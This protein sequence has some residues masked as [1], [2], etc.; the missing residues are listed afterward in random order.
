[1][2]VHLVLKNNLASLRGKHLTF[3]GSAHRHLIRSFSSHHRQ[4]KVSRNSPDNAKSLKEFYLLEHPETF[5]SVDPKISNL[6]FKSAHRFTLFSRGALCA[7]SYLE[8]QPL[9]G[10]TSRHHTLKHPHF[11]GIFIHFLLNMLV[12]KARITQQ[13][14][15]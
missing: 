8:V 5:R 6:H 12:Y 4:T 2:V 14:Y 11:E 15:Q 9:R 10:Q 3:I 13:R 1:M 7:L